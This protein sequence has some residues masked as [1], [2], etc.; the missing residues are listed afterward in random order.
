MM[1]EETKAAITTASNGQE[2]IDL[3]QT[4]EPDLLFLDIQ[5]PVLDGIEACQRIKGIYPQKTIIALTANVMQKD[6][7]HYRECGFDDHLGK[8][9]DIHELFAI[10]KKYLG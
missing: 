10:A 4:N 2:A 9:V 3:A 6:I 5:M 1:M 7:E 8:P